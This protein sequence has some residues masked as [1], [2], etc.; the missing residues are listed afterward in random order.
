M[1]K[2]LE[3][4]KKLL[5]E[6]LAKHGIAAP[7]KYN[8]DYADVAQWG[9]LDRFW[10]RKL[11]NGCVFGNFDKETS[12][13][14]YLGNEPLNEMS[15][16]VLQEI[17]AEAIEDVE[18]RLKFE[19]KKTSEE[20]SSIWK[21]SS[22]T[23]KAHPYLEKNQIKGLGCRQKEDKLVCRL[24]DRTTNIC[25][26][27]YIDKDGNK[28]FLGNKKRGCYFAIGEPQ[29]QKIIVCADFI[30]G[31][32][33]HEKT[34]EAVAV[35][36]YQEN[37][38]PVKEALLSKHPDYDIN[39]ASDDSAKEIASGAETSE[40]IDILN[41][42]NIG[43][44][45]SSPENSQANCDCNS[46]TEQVKNEPVKGDVE[47]KTNTT[48][49]KQNIPNGYILKDDG[50]F[51][52][53]DE[54]KNIS[55]KVSG[56]IEVLAES[57]DDE[58]NNWCK[59]VKFEDPDGIFKIVL[60]PYDQLG[61]NGKELEENLWSK[62]LY[63]N[64]FS[65]LKQY[66]IDYNTSNRVRGIDKIGWYRNVFVYPD[67]SV[68]GISDEN[69]IYY[70]N[71]IFKEFHKNGN[72]EDWRDN[73]GKYC[74]GN[75][76][77]ILAV[78]AAF[79]G[80]LLYIT[81]QENGGFH[82]VGNSTIGKTTILNVA[83]SVYGDRSFMK[84]WRATDNGL[85]GIA[86]TRNDTLLILDELGE[87][88][89]SGKAGEIAYMLGNGNGKI[90]SHKDGSAKKSYTWRLLYLSSGEKDLNDCAMESKKIVKAGQEIRLLNIPAQPNEDSF[91]AFENVHDKKTG[92]AFSEYLNSAV[93]EYHGTA[94]RE[95]I[96]CIVDDGFEKIT[97]EFKA[98][99]GNAE[100][101]YLPNDADNQVKRAF[102][103]FM[104]IAFAGEYASKKSITGWNE[105]ESLNA[106]VTCF[107]D[108]IK[109]RGGVKDQ[110]PKALLEQVRLFFEKNYDSRFNQVY[111]INYDAIKTYNAV[112]YAER[113]ADN[114]Y[115]YYVFSQSFKEIC[116]G[117]NLD[118]A[119]NT[120]Y[121]AGWIENKEPKQ[122]GE[123]NEYRGKRVYIFTS[124]VWNDEN[125]E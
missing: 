48:E 108:W 18:S 63:I 109:E 36:F 40:A 27:L 45:T 39:I 34:G 107:N 65:E 50:L 6:A 79:A 83:C 56:K 92:K 26:L 88:G 118:F 78:G 80:T 113:Q 9:N 120:L 28:E 69:I 114:T 58:S 122:L 52:I 99:L 53:D 95:F 8:F 54:K 111:D 51:K 105:E 4:D 100:Q 1:Y 30:K 44:C 96:K 38:E 115:K 77:L 43:I 14:V 11:G 2:L 67:G 91:G 82:F 29:N 75:T 32:K 112:G 13:Y 85:E 21:N 23:D 20:A 106:C 61:P 46:M 59:V 97:K 81:G 60:I 17:Y 37:L 25:N 84:T 62:G 10:V 73:I 19:D 22:K 31:A 104:L 102:N 125:I 42:Y 117:F 94:S 76:R 7:E 16:K 64:K 86:A 70:G 87:L 71:N 24:T 93:K 68:I 90:R 12:D 35:A 110:E 124:K 101:K 66:L 49:S 5:E 123:R 121:N 72:L 55:H 89:D 98:F 33:I 116:T 74:Q 41:K 57:K 119:K 15:T 103:R 3:E 47:T